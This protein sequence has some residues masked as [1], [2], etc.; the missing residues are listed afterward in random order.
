METVIDIQKKNEI[1]L[2]FTVQT[3]TYIHYMILSIFTID[4]TLIILNYQLLL[5]IRLVS[6]NRI[7]GKRVQL[8]RSVISY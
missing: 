5:N 3:E 8:Q 2:I 6:N 7:V 1:L 4:V